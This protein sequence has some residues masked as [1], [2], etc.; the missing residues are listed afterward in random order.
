MNDQDSALLDRLIEVVRS[1]VPMAT[2][3]SALIAIGEAWESIQ[4]MKKGDKIEVSV[5]LDV[6][7][8]QGD[9]EFEEG[10]FACLRVDDEGIDLSVLSTQYDKQVGSDHSTEDYARFGTEGEFDEFAVGE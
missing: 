1:F 6:G 7:F 5:G 4:R 8:R 3:S 2:S 9:D 10:V